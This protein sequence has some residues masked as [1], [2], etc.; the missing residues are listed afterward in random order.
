MLSYLLDMYVERN[1]EKNSGLL[2]REK[3]S[4]FCA[5]FQA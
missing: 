4:D 5:D 2:N 1:H 3:L